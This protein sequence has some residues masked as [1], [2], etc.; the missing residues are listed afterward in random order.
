MPA[1]ASTGARLRIR[2]LA[3][4]V[5]RRSS[6]TIAPMRLT[7]PGARYHPA[8]VSEAQVREALVAVVDPEIRRSVVEL[9]MVRGV[10]IDGPRVDV[11][12]A[13]TVAGCPMKAN[14]EQQVQQ[15]VGGVDGVEAVA[16]TFDV[17]S[18]EQR[19]DL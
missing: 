14:L 16:V 2:P 4:N 18:A 12:I 1:T 11:T 5:F 15:H 13:L 10:R 7:V 9:E 17:M 19:T 6:T 3:G 8:M